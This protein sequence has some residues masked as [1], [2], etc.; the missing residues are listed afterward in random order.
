MHA[1]I[2]NFGVPCVI[3]TVAICVFVRHHLRH[4]VVWRIRATDGNLIWTCASKETQNA[5]ADAS[6]SASATDA[7]GVCVTVSQ[8]SRPGEARAVSSRAV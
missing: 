2:W 3:A 6:E 7:S 1:L 5:H 4:V 8:L